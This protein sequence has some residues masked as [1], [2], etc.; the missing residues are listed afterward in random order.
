MNMGDYYVRIYVCTMFMICDETLIKHLEKVIN[1]IY[2]YFLLDRM[3]GRHIC[4]II[5]DCAA[6]ASFA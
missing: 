4:I 2:I 3:Q 6:L 5:T 1:H